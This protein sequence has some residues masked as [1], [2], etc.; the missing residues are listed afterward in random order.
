[1]RKRTRI[2]IFAYLLI[3]CFW[4]SMSWWSRINRSGRCSVEIKTRRRKRGSGAEPTW[5]GYD[6][7]E[8]DFD[9]CCD[10]LNWINNK[11]LILTV[12]YL[13]TF[14]LSSYQFLMRTLVLYGRFPRNIS[15]W[16][17]MIGTLAYVPS[18]GSKN[19]SVFDVIEQVLSRNE[20]L[21]ES[22]IL[23]R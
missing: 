22:H 12:V 5:T 7:S 18:F 21:V 10:S 20:S 4:W 17:G 16:T 15:R 6:I 14:D 23:R 1:M 19:R 8:D 9:R 2:V 3:N 13:L 11:Y